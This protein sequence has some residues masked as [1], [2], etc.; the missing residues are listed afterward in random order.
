VSPELH[1]GNLKDIFKI[2]KIVNDNKIKI[3]AV[4]VKQKFIKY[5]DQAS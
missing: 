1:G 4:C 5:W 2:Q 3:D